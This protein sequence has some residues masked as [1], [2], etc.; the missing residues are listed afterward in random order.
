MQHLQT[1]T[2]G[3]GDSV[4]HRTGSRRTAVML[5]YAALVVAV[6][7]MLAACGGDSSDDQ[8]SSGDTAKSGDGGATAAASIDSE[9]AKEFRAL[10][11]I[12]DEDQKNLAGKKFKFGAILPLSGPGAE[13]ATTQQNGVKLAVKQMKDYV[14]MD[15]EFSAK[16]HKSGDPQAGAASARELGI[17]GFGTAI[18]SYY[19]V[20]GSILPALSKY[21]MLSFDPG[22][23]IIPAVQ[24]KPYFWGTRAQ[25]PNDGFD[26]TYQYVKQEMPD[27]KRVALVVWDSGASYYDPI[28]EDLKR[29]LAANGLTLVGRQLQKI[30]QTDYSAIFS[31]LKNMKPDV[32]QLV[33][34]GT[35]P[36]YFMKGYASSGL[37]A[38]V[39]GSEFV[40]AA[41]KVAGA[42]YDKYWFAN[43]YFDFAQP[44]NPLSKFFMKTYAAEF[45][46]EATVF[47]S[48]N[49]YESSLAYLDLA[50]RVAAEGGDINSGKQLQDALIADPK[51]KSVYGGDE[52]TV[53][54]LV[55]DT[56][57]H[58]PA[59]RSIGLF[60]V[61]GGTPKQL[62]SFDIGGAD[63]EVT[64]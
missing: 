16:D 14:G 15:V 44:P 20:F 49:Y 18:S 38:Q 9:D 4:R 63:F 25:T 8:A 55:L 35:D 53:G 10:M 28:T 31:Q 34:Y 51:L 46:E 6:M 29:V 39:I 3:P 23:G 13:Y 57:T 43:D 58:S 36:G 48:P 19:G 60:E 30:G 59:S 12:S 21:E 11:G 5:A 33:S 45:G 41:A 50:K 1:D 17:D 24:G 26:G 27:A 40:P 42:A 61:Q 64:R 54:E 22:G 52:S 32:I 7:L 56:K 2:G 62:A 47:Y 37:D